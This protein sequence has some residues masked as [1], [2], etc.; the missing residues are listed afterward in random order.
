MKEFE[1][2][3]QADNVQAP[4]GFEDRVLDLLHERRSRKKKVRT[5]QWSLAGAFAAM[6]LLVVTAQVFF[7]GPPPAPQT[8]AVENRAL[9]KKS[10]PEESTIPITEAVTFTGEPMSRVRDS[11]TIY[12]LEQVSDSTDTRIIY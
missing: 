12:I 1:R 11:K 2:L 8:D 10:L 9:T 4:P 3:R 7:I 6:T 5:I